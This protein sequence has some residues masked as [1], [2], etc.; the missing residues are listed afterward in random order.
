MIVGTCIN[1]RCKKNA[2]LSR[3]LCMNCK[4][5]AGSLVRLGFTSWEKLEKAGKILP[6]KLKSV[7][8]NPIY[9]WLMEGVDDESTRPTKVKI[10][11]TR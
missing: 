9:K 8:D 5:A 10:R 3:G 6:K 1:P 11:P 2:Q 7:T 4:S